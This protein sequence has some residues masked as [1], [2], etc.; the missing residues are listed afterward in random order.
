MI[1]P[2]IMGLYQW[3]CPNWWV[4]T[5]VTT[6]SV[7]IKSIGVAILFSQYLIH[8]YKLCFKLLRL[9]ILISES[10]QHP[11]NLSLLSVMSH[12]CVK[13]WEVL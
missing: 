6:K 4:P 12:V 1:G 11:V 5:S 8:F 2:P 13:Y 9:L 10:C 7:N 3:L